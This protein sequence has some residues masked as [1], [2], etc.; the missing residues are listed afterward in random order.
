MKKVFYKL[1][2]PIRNWYWFLF[3]S[4]TTGVKV[5][6]ESE[7][8]VLMIKNTYGKSIW[9][10]PG[11]A[12]RTNEAP[13]T[14]AEREVL[15]EVGLRIKELR[16]IGELLSTWEHKRDTIHC[17]VGMANNRTIK[18]DPNEIQE[19]S[20]FNKNQLPP[21]ISTVAKEVVALWTPK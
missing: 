15:E 1:V 16:K 10:F 5:V 2:R 17:Y 7:R 12:V 19:A 18:I 14:A 9:T 8:D 21:E 20:W 11:G 13:K 3:R 4:K 6:V